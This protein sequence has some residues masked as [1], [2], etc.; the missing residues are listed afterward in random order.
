MAT[1]D[2]LIL[3]DDVRRIVDTILATPGEMVSAYVAVRVVGAANEPVDLTLELTGPDGHGLL[4][5]VQP[6]VLTA[7]GTRIWGGHVQWRCA[8]PGMYAISASANGRARTTSVRI[9]RNATDHRPV[10]LHRWRRH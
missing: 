6:L 5:L 9:Q 7:A 3:C 4:Q 1:I 10:T 2:W 8:A